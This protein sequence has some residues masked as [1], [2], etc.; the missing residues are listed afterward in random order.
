MKAKLFV[1]G[2]Y[3]N[4]KSFEYGFVTGSNANGFSSGKTRQTGLT[5]EIE[6][7]RQEHFE[8]WAM[9]NYLKKYVEVHIEEGVNSMGRTRVLKF[10]DTFLLELHTRYSST[11]NEPI[12]FELLMK[13]GAI[14]ASWSTAKH[15]EKWGELPNNEGEVTVIEQPT[16]QITSLKWVNSDT[17]EE[18]ITEIGYNENASLIAAIENDQGGMATITIEKEDGSEFENG[19]KQLTFSEAIS[20]GVV[21]LTPMEIKE[22]WEEFKTSDI[23]KLVG[24][25]SVGEVAKTSKPLVV[26][27]IPK[28]TLHF[29]PHNGWAGE[30]G[31]DWMR[32]KDTSIDGDID[33]KLDVGEYGVVYATKPTAV[34][35]NKDYNLLENEYSPININ[36]RKDASG[37][38]LLPYHIPWL[39]IYREPNIAIAPYAELELLSE[40]DVVPDE[41]YIEF[42]KQYFD[43]SGSTDSPI[44]NTVKQYKLPAS[45]K[46]KTPTGSFN[47]VNIKLQCINTLPKD[48]TINVW[49][50][51]KK[52]DGT[53]D[54]PIL[55]GQ[56]KVKANSKVNRRVS[57]I[58]FVNVITNI[59]SKANSID[60]ISTA[61]KPIQENN[62]IPFLKQ[63]L[64]KPDVSN[65]KL[66]LFD[67]SKAN[68]QTLNTDY[69]LLNG[70]SNIFNKYSNSGGDSLVNFLKQQFNSIPA[71]NKYA[72]HFKVFFL[73]EAGGKLKSDGTI[74]FLGGHANGINSK[75]CVMY[76]N[77][78]PFYVAHELMHCMGLHHSFDNNSK[79]TFKIGQTENIMDYSHIS[80]YATPNG[81]LTQISTW[82]WQW[83]TLKNSNEKEI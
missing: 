23:D 16:P 3:Y 13:S 49:A 64:V 39:S 35:T 12:S 29:R 57:K 52:A 30:F 60:G 2:E 15:V 74:G 73:G 25:V 4:L 75:E 1:D 22:Q 63:A 31:F 36:N 80:S 59:N 26:K 27:P 20:N 68:V 42:S 37:T 55:S 81:T 41:F 10:H 56:L 19:Q 5:C 17:Q 28:A 79:H 14:E 7:I 62:L 82:Q 44:D 8:K 21:E 11:S 77:P 34:F 48:E 43:I 76:S 24:K 45:M 18:N 83:D 47:K 71:N 9:E 51:N 46:G 72:N 32:M 54:T 38:K 70:R 53:L 69:I 58:V 6:A 66:N 40:V 61:N 50:V 65:E 67:N 33:Y 78:K